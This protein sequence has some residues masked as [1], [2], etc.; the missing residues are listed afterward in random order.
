MSQAAVRRRDLV[1][2]LADEIL[3]QHGRGRVIVAVDGVEGAGTSPFAAELVERLQRRG[4]AAFHAR[5]DDFQRSR[6]RQALG[7][8]T[9][10]GR[11]RYTYDYSALHRALIDPFLM[12][13]ST[14]FVAAHHDASRD[15]PI[16]PTWLTASDDAVLVIDGI[17]LQRPEL[18]GLW[19][20]TIWIDVPPRAAWARLV[21]ADPLSHDADAWSLASGAQ[22][23]Y[24]KEVNP[25]ASASAV[26]DNRDP[27]DPKRIA[28]GR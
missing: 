21:E 4:H 22:K 10:I 25:R 8:A 15:Q 14:G 2:S 11:Y 17:Y 19:S 23:L 27:E 18:R 5:L 7:G 20:F 28:A 26:I 3:Q 12:G 13:G 1:T 16:E 9:A 6:A 24:G